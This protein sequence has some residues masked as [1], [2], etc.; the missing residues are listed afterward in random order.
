M[1]AVLPANTASAAATAGSRRS[2][3]PQFA[4]TAISAIDATLL[5]APAVAFAAALC[6]S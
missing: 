5:D 6:R 1:V 4:F 2:C 3:S